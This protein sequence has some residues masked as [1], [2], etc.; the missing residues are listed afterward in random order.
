MEHRAAFNPAL[1]STTT[2]CLAPIARM[3]SC[4]PAPA[5]TAYDVATPGLQRVS[6]GAL[7]PQ[8]Y[9]VVAPCNVSPLSGLEALVDTLWLEVQLESA[10]EQ[11]SML[12]TDIGDGKN[13]PV[14]DQQPEYRPGELT[15]VPGCVCSRPYETSQ[16]KKPQSEFDELMLKVNAVYGPQVALQITELVDMSLAEL[17]AHWR[18]GQPGSRYRKRKRQPR[19]IRRRP[20]F[21]RQAKGTLSEFDELMLK[22]DAVD[23]PEPVLHITKLEYMSLAELRA[24]WR[25]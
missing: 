20:Y 18:A 3:E 16:A 25:A 22:L 14:V 23:G 10:L 6:E 12:S 9:A 24:N 2:A 15:E 8:N 4:T 21:S 13:S 11:A 5:S 17:R 7:R 1:P 19:N